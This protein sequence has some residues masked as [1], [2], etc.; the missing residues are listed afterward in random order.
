MAFNPYSQC[1]CPRT[2]PSIVFL[3]AV[4]CSD[5]G[6]IERRQRIGVEQHTVGCQITNPGACQLAD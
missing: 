1:G 4:D 5:V 6:M 3:D 2:M